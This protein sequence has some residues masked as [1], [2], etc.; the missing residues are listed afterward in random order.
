MPV[1]TVPGASGNVLYRIQYLV[2]ACFRPEGIRIKLLSAQKDDGP[3]YGSDPEKTSFEFI[4]KCIKNGR[5]VYSVLERQKSNSKL[6]FSSRYFD[7][8]QIFEKVARDAS[9]SSSSYAPSFFEVREKR[10]RY[11][12]T[13][14]YL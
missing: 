12:L 14:E 5:L 7:E 8:K 10:F 6:S 9:S 11:L 3:R 2:D 13:K 1:S 4:K